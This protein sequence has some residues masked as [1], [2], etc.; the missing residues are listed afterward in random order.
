MKVHCNPGA[1]FGELA[2]VDAAKGRF[3][4]P[5]A[6]CAN[7]HVPSNEKFAFEAKPR[8]P[9]NRAQDYALPPYAPQLFHWL[10]RKGLVSPDHLVALGTDD[11]N[12]VVIA[13]YW[14]RPAN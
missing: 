8:S 11:I 9:Y 7:K 14:F 3:C 6:V 2:E 10:S 5:Q 12:P 4:C 1:S 13:D